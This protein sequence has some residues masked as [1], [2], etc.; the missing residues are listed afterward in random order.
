MGKLLLIFVFWLSA[1]AAPAVAQVQQNDIDL[2]KQIDMLPGPSPTPASSTGKAETTGS[3]KEPTVITATQEA[4]FD[5]KLRMAVFVGAVYIQ[6]PQF[7]LSSDKLTVYF[8]KPEDSKPGTGE[9]AKGAPTAKPTP[10][11]SSAP[12]K[13]GAAP[14]PGANGLERAVAEG[15]VVVTSDRPDANGG[16]STHYVGRGEKVD[17]NAVNGEAILT[18]WPQVEQGINTIVSTEESTVMYLY[19]DGKMNSKGGTRTV[20]HDPGPGKTPDAKAAKTPE[21]K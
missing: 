15:N 4:T 14:T 19:K 7:T 9:K 17:Y 13:P 2:F 20:V 18:G 21:A 3:N 12:A 11:T 6:D 8:K 1:M 16:P 10:A 5:S